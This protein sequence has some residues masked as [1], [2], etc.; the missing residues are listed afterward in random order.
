MDQ[1]T[2]EAPDR[3][4]RAAGEQ[5]QQL[6]VPEEEGADPFRNRQC[7]HPVRDRLEDFLDQTIAPERSLPPLHR[8]LLLR[9]FA[10]TENGSQFV[11]GPMGVCRTARCC[12][13][14]R[15]RLARVLDRII[16]RGIRIRLTLVIFYIML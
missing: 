1:V 12:S 9:L 13:D 7:D 14:T 10:A 4:G 8:L 6:A 16:G 5:T 2:L 3:L 15:G 11:H